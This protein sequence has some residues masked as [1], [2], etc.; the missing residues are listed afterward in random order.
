MNLDLA[1]RER[2]L[3]GTARSCAQSV[4]AARAATRDRDES[5]P[6]QEM[7]ALARL[8]L[9]GV[10]VQPVWGGAGAGPVVLAH[11]IREIARADAAVAVTLAV[12]NMVAEILQ[13]FGSP[14]V[15]D[16]W[17]PRLCGGQAVAGAFALSEPG[18]GSD[19][20]AIQTRAQPVAGGYLLNGSKAW[21]TSG[22]RA[23]VLIVVARQLASGEATTPPSRPRLSAFVVEHGTRGLSPG[24]HERKMGQ[25][26][27]STVALTLEDVFVPTAQRLGA[28]GEG[29][30]IA[31]AALDGG[32]I[33]VGALAVGVGQ[34]T[35]AAAQP[36]LT[37]VAALSA[38][39][40]ALEAAWLLVARAAWRKHTG[41]P[42]TRAAAQAKLFAT[43]SAVTACDRAVAAV[44]AAGLRRETGL[45]RGFRDARVTTIYEG[46]SQ[47][48]RV[49]IARRWLEERQRGLTLD[50]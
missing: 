25:R 9:C 29:L 37:D 31:L 18:A 5:F 38:D 7:L 26:G 39:E 19:A 34:A 17:L 16:R 20:A 13:R 12:T 6:A 32:R 46:T 10:A 3:V 8:G 30:A 21:T 28:E 36:L 50:L 2:P 41:Q 48:Q 22:D 47:I 42:V 27:S 40:A 49:V 24:R 23:G 15:R 1:P 33:N 4:L 35:L 44:G 45:E 11:V 14:G 43:E